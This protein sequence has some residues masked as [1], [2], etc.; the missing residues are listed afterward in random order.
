[1]KEDTNM[2][3][4]RKAT[5]RKPSKKEIMKKAEKRK[6][7]ERMQQFIEEEARYTRPTEKSKTGLEECRKRLKE[8]KICF[9]KE[10]C[11]C[12]GCQARSKES[13]E[14]LCSLE[15]LIQGG[16]CAYGCSGCSEC[17]PCY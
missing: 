9:C 11:D 16:G 15:I 13:G 14:G 3:K 17:N 2:S 1:M 4:L 8:G 10:R 7:E 6:A 5:S 12:R